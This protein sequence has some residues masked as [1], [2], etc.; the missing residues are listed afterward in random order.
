MEELFF[1]RAMYSSSRQYASSL[2]VSATHSNSLTRM[3]GFLTLG[4]VGCVNVAESP[5]PLETWLKDELQKARVQRIFP[6]TDNLL[7]GPQ[8]VD[9]ELTKILL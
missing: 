6:L 4:P 2:G 1:G 8:V 9:E 5:P 3:R 7:A